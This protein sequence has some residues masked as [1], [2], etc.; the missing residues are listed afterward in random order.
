MGKKGRHNVRKPKGFGKK[1]PV[2]GQVAKEKK[3]GGK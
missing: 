2:V 1:L 3:E